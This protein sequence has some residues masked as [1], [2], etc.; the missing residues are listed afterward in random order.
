MDRP[1][2]PPSAQRGFTLIEAS[3]VIVIMG[4]M[5]AA[6]AMFL[7]HPVEAYI[8]QARRADLSDAADA[9]LRRMARDIQRALPNSV[10]VDPTGKVIEFLP[11]QAAGRYRAEA[12]PAGTADFFDP[13]SSSDSSFEV[14]GPAVSIA[15][16]DQLVIYNLGLTGA[17]AYAGSNRRGI[18]TPGVVTNIGYSLAGGQFPY[19]S[20]SNRFQVIRTPVTYHCVDV[21]GGGGTITRYE[22]YAIQVAQPV[23]ASAPPLSTAPNAAVLVDKV[24]SCSF[25][26]APAVSQRNG[27]LTARLTIAAGGESVSLLHQ[28]HVD[29]SP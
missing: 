21:A 12:D 11:I 27:L 24:A 20:P 10:R 17:D 14:L 6:A 13:T 15:A 8:D 5:A 4:V 16:G 3:I 9:A 28:I 29:N 23:N 26:Y 2:S 22:G 7:R 18:L 1:A 19:A 25:V